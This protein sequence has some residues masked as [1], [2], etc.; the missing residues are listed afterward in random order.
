VTA[1]TDAI[2][3]FLN[4]IGLYRPGR[5][6]RIVPLTGGVSSDIALVSTDGTPDLVVKRALARL[7]VEAEWTAPVER[8]RYE[9]RWLDV[10]GTLAPGFCPRLLG[11]DASTGYL[12]MEALDPA[13]HAV[14]KTHLL[15]GTVDRHVATALGTRLAAVHTRTAADPALA[16]RFDTGDLFEALRIS[17]YLRAIARRHP[18]LSPAV[19][20]LIDRLTGTRVA[21]VH[22]DVSPKNILVGPRGPV[23]LDAECAWWGDP[24]FDLAFCLTHLLL[25]SLARPAHADGLLACARALTTAYRTGIASLGDGPASALDSRAAALLPALL[26][27]RVDGDSPVEYLDPAEADLIRRTAPALV[28]RPPSTVEE[29]IS[30]WQVPR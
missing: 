20:R 21:L 18:D 28:R 9:A 3:G 2:A 5:P 23:L 7:R 14:W 16:D 1:D 19:D 17:P 8:S 25:K 22:G 15:A 27:A 29:M 30:M 13:T 10:V 24:A 4:R 6:I 11:Y 26:L 12:A